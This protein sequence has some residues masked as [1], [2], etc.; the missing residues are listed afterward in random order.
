ME[1]AARFLQVGPPAWEQVAKR[2]NVGVQ[3]IRC[4]ARFWFQWPV[5]SASEGRDRL[6]RCKMVNL[7]ESWSDLLGGTPELTTFATRFRQSDETV[8]TATFGTIAQAVKGFL[9]REHQRF[10]PSHAVA[11]DLDFVLHEGVPKGVDRDD[12]KE[13]LAVS[14]GRGKKIVDRLGAAMSK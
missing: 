1:T 10:V 3:V 14:W 5:E 4:G 7:G 2:L 9:P 6:A 11:V 8:L 12:L 13:F